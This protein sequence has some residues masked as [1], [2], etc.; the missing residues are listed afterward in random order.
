MP[1]FH[2]T[3][4]YHLLRMKEMG[5]VYWCHSL[6][7]FGNGLV[8]IFIPIFLLKTGYS[9]NEVLTYLFLQQMFAALW[10]FPTASLFK[11]LRPH[12]MLALGS[13]GTIM[14]IALLI[15]LPEQRWPLG[16]LALAWAFNRCVY[17]A[18]FHYTFAAARAHVRAKQQIA[19]IVSINV[20]ASAVAPAIGGLT[21]SF[22][23]INYT[24]VAGLAFLI[25]AAT[26]ILFGS[27]GPPKVNIEMN[28]GLF[29]LM[30][31]DALAN[32]F[33]GTI[34]MAEFNLWPLLV[35]LLVGSYAG[36]G[37]LSSVIV[38]ASI[39]VTLYVGDRK[40]RGSDQRHIKGGLLTYSL[41]SLG[42]TIAQTGTQIFSL[43]ML[44]GIGRS[45]YVTP[46]MNR[47]YT[48]SD[49][50]ERLAYVTTMETAFSIGSAL[51]VLVLLALATV[52]EP[53]TVLSLGLGIVALSPLGVRLI[54]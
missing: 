40:E 36:V 16:L 20:F 6:I 32:A 35:F 39:L 54:R 26:P 23:G 31:R 49:S 37:L 29:K 2:Q 8:A 4:H 1:Y 34:S 28:W 38:I 17:W 52:F 13:L 25:V 5:R 19:G 27:A 10:Q 9:F 53:S 14:L 48:N 18:A 50:P 42:R 51:Y 45:L 46:F 43:N 15:S 24:Y 3:S 44:A 47:Y 41:T 11:Y 12:L 33:N 21:A 22:M 7:S 30:W